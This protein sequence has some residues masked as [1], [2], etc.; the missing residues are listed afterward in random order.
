MNLNEGTAE[1]RNLGAIWVRRAKFGPRNLGAIW[2]RRAQFGPR[3]LGTPRAQINLSPS[4][5]SSRDRGSEPSP[6]ACT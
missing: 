6:L 3:N 5:Q 1:A 2:V 4:Y